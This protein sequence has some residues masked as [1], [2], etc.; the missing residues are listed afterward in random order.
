M[1]FTIHRGSSE[2]GGNCIE[3][4]SGE[5][6]LVLDLGMPLFDANR[7]PINT[8]SFKRMTS[9]ELRTVGILPAVDGLYGDCMKDQ[10]ATP[11]AILLSHAHLDHTGLLNH[12]NSKIPVYTSRGTSKMMLAG[13]LFAGQIGLSR[14]R[15]REIEAEKPKR[16]GPFTVT[17]YNVD[18]SIYAGM[19]FLIEADGKRL[20]Y[21]GD[22]RLH[23]RK[24]GMHRRIV[25][26]LSRTQIDTMLMEGTHMGL[27]DGPTIGEYRLEELIVKRI[28]TSSGLML[29]SFSPQH[30]DRFVTFIRA[31]IR[32]KRTLVVDLY[33]AFILH[34]LRNELP[35]PVPEHSN[36]LRVFVPVN[37]RKKAGLKSIS[38]LIK[39]FDK[40]IIQIEEVIESP[41]KFVMVF[42]PSML[43][44]DF[45]GC[46][47]NQTDC[48]Y[49]RWNGYLADPDWKQV[50]A[51]IGKAGGR[52]FDEH[53]SGHI[54]S[55]DIVYFVNA[56]APKL[57]IPIHTFEPERFSEQFANSLVLGDGVTHEIE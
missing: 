34:L 14:D 25:E 52:L 51:E 6:R 2:V 9:A 31:S 41:E 57:V 46:L 16:I 5:S 15:F 40:A 20:F 21:S 10:K 4:I 36:H 22:L 18:H 19:A 30:L 1:K 48:V 27:P 35:L 54:L 43:K 33:S 55:A 38:K 45:N 42:R 3:V 39:Q 32:T 17:A 28:K 12:S 53:T 26:A 11:V 23:G 56:L 24:P 37:Q 13:S 50:V 44:D 47:P 49:S 8:Y 29:A 7:Q